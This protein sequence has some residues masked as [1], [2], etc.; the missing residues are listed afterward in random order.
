LASLASAAPASESRLSLDE[1]V[2]F[3]MAPGWF[4]LAAPA[5]SYVGSIPAAS[6]GGALMFRLLRATWSSWYWTPIQFQLGLGANR[7]AFM[8]SLST[9]LGLRHRMGPWFVEGGVALGPG[10]FLVEYELSDCDGGCFAGGGPLLLE[11]VVRVGKAWSRVRMALFARPIVPLSWF[12][13]TTSLDNYTIHSN[14]GL[15]FGLDV[16]IRR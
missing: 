12:R 11:P 2:G 9:E 14:A 4:N 5:T 7:A 16:G 3:E 15:M 6:L 13:N 1:Y 10:R 8:F